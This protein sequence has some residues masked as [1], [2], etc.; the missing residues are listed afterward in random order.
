MIFSKT[1]KKGS[2][3]DQHENWIPCDFLWNHLPLPPQKNLQKNKMLQPSLTACRWGWMLLTWRRAGKM[4]VAPSSLHCSLAKRA[5]FCVALSLCQSVAKSG[6]PWKVT[7]SANQRWGVGPV[8]PVSSRGGGGSLWKVHENSAR[9]HGW[10]IIFTSPLCALSRS[11]LIHI[12]K[13][14]LLFSFFFLL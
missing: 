9:H 11:L 7:L 8:L 6:A 5:A 2:F 1:T 3:S 10:S 4:A 13:L 12:G 14:L